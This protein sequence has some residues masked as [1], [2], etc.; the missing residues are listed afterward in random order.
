MWPVR[1][2]S[3]M[4]GQ[5]ERSTSVP[6]DLFDIQAA[7]KVPKVVMSEK[8]KAMQTNPSQQNMPYAKTNQKD[9]FD[10]KQR[11]E[12]FVD[13]MLQLYKSEKRL[14]FKRNQA[15]D[16]MRLAPVQSMKPIKSILGEYAK[17]TTSGFSC[18]VLAESL[19]RL[20]QVTA[21]LGNHPVKTDDY[22]I[23]DMD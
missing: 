7:E 2:K 6:N 18:Q 5:Q 1:S 4:T 22:S 9:Y 10:K 19:K 13:K 17:I 8:N 20:N 3:T 15:Y 12:I 11:Y 21:A 16:R 14:S 23:S